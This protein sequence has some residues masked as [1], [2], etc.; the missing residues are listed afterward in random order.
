MPCHR[1][2]RT[3]RAGCAPRARSRSAARL[4]I[5]AVAQ[6]LEA[7]GVARKVDDRLP[8]SP[9]GCHRRGSARSRRGSRTRRLLRARAAPAPCRRPSPPGRCARRPGRRR[10]RGTRRMRRIRSATSRRVSRPRWHTPGTALAVELREGVL[11]TAKR[12]DLHRLAQ[13]I[14]H[15]RQRL[16][17]RGR[18]PAR[19]ARADHRRDPQ[20]GR[21]GGP[22]AGVKQRAIEARFDLGDAHA[23]DCPRPRSP[24]QRVLANRS[25]LGIAR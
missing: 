19:R 15:D 18:A 8:R 5:P 7:R 17:R 3:A 16:E 6:P 4:R 11:V 9:R 25:W 22:S 14:R 23:V 20:G 2:P 24:I 10:R 12:M 1:P 13:R 21:G